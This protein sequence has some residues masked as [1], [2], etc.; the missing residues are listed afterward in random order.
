MRLSRRLG[1]QRVSRASSKAKSSLSQVEASRQSGKRTQ[2]IT[3]SKGGARRITST[4]RGILRKMESPPPFGRLAA[5]CRSHRNDVRKRPRSESTRTM[6]PALTPVAESPDSRARIS[7]NLSRITGAA[8]SNVAA[9]TALEGRVSCAL[10]LIR[11]LDCSSFVTYGPGLGP[12][13]MP[14]PEP[15]KTNSPA[16]LAGEMPCG[17]SR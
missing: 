1:V 15:E 10:R 17:T 5:G 16:P 9:P 3:N 7:E 4:R 11:E 2:T 14:V 12:M 13:P 6:P 8:A